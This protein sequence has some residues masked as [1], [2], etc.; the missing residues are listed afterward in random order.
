M[1]KLL[2]SKIGSEVIEKIFTV[3]II[4]CSGNSKPIY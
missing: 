1:R 3:D 2:M 4:C